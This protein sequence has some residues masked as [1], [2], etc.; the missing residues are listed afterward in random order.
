M[1]EREM[2]DENEYLIAENAKL[3]RQRDML[4][5]ALKE[6]EQVKAGTVTTSYDMRRIAIAAIAAVESEK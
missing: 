5:E 6:I 1:D 3:K 2:T 4:L